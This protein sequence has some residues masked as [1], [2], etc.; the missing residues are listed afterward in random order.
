MTNDNLK[1]GSPVREAFVEDLVRGLTVALKLEPFVVSI[2]KMDCGPQSTTV[3]F[4]LE[5]SF[6]PSA[7]DV[8]TSCET[9]TQLLAIVAP[10]PGEVAAAGTLLW[11]AEYSNS[12]GKANV[13]SCHLVKSRDCFESSV[14]SIAFVSFTDPWQLLS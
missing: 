10:P 11:E 5:Q 4:E 6:N 9:L 2:G 12:W 3:V 13:V 1:E 14:K 8:Q 7:K